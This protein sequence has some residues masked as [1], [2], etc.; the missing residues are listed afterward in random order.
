MEKITLC[1]GGAGEEIIKVK[2]IEIPDLW[3][4]AMWL[5]KRDMNRESDMVLKTWGLAHD[6]K[7]ALLD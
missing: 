6:L 5:M 4:I 3:H 2:D 7:N 1:K